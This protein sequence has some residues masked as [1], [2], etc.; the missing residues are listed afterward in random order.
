MVVFVRYPFIWVK[1]LLLAKNKWNSKSNEQLNLV[2]KNDL[3]HV[4]WKNNIFSIA[5]TEIPTVKE[6]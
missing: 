2:S 1:Q 5:W 3:L 4:S 6:S